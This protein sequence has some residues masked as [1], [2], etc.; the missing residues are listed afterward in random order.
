MIEENTGTYAKLLPSEDTRNKIALIMTMFNLE[1]HTSPRDL[2]VTLIYSRS[3]CNIVKET[4]G[5]PV[6]ANGKAF[7]IFANANG[8][9]CLV[10]ELESEE[11]QSLHKRFITDHGA[12]HSYDSYKPHLTLSY[13]YNSTD[14]PSDTMLEHFYHLCFD[15]VVVEPLS[16][17]W[18]PNEQED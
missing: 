5:L 4:V 12:T 8:G 9:N 3:E 14:V 16:F 2:H 10:V 13:D 7:S 17:D 1:N 6:R 18:I 11:M 15:Q